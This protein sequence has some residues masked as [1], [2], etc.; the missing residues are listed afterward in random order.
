M[1]ADERARLD[2]YLL[3]LV[4]EG[5]RATERGDFMVAR[6]C[7]ELRRILWDSWKPASREGEEG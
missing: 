6:T 4:E 3:W 1:S 5:D 7:E 2:A